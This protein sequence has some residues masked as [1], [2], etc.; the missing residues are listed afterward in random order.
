MLSLRAA[1]SAMQRDSSHVYA[2]NLCLSVI[3]CPL[4]H[5]SGKQ[6]GILP[7]PGIVFCKNAMVPYGVFCLVFSDCSIHY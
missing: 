7:P 5:S 4:R 2:L 3:S 1:W 6:A